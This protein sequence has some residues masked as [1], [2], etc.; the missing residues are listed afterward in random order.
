MGFDCLIVGLGNPGRE[1]QQTRHNAGFL[2]ADF[3]AE[4]LRFG[5]WETSRRLGDAECCEGRIGELRVL[6]AKPQSFMNRSGKPVRSIWSY[7]DS[8]ESLV[9]I[10]DELDLPLGEVRLK[11]GGGDGGHNGVRSIVS[12]L[13]TKD[14]FRVRLGIGRPPLDWQRDQGGDLG[15]SAWVLSRF[16]QSEL[17]QLKRV[18]QASLEAVEILLAEGLESAQR[19]VHGKS[20]S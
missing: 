17:A 3:I 13:S 20:F 15:V 9:V 19:H 2:L 12:E 6:L 4:Q 14:F 10:H 5:S 18:F 1:Y 11:I 8:F 16:S 7:Y